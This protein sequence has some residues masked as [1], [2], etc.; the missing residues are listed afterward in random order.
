M[1]GDCKIIVLESFGNTACRYLIVITHSSPKSLLRFRFGF[2]PSRC[3]HCGRGWQS[4]HL[5][6]SGECVRTSRTTGKARRRRA[7]NI[8][9][10]SSGRRLACRI[11]WRSAMHFPFMFYS[12]SRAS[13][14]HDLLMKAY[15]L[16]QLP[17]GQRQAVFLVAYW[18]KGGI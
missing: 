5:R 18:G 13:F 2:A 1:D 6:A 7:R 10:V 16:L 3:H 4:S 17:K 11:D 14:S 15:N 12:K 8:R 9:S